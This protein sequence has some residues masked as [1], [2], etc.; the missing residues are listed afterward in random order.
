MEDIPAIVGASNEI[1][2][3]LTVQPLLSSSH[4][5]RPTPL[6]HLQRRSALKAAF[7][8]FTPP[9]MQTMSV[10]QACTSSTLYSEV[11][12]LKESTDKMLDFKSKHSRFPPAFNNMVDFT[13][14]VILY[15]N[16][17]HIKTISSQCVHSIFSII[18]YCH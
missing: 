13:I 5:P 17:C 8:R 7:M 16:P 6:K 15:T 12:I 10:S 11:L 4:V 3:P 14:E 9:S 2:E 18:E 1:G